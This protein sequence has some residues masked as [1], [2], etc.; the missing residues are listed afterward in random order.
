[1]AIFNKSY[2]KIHKKCYSQ[3]LGNSFPIRP[4][5]ASFCIF[6]SSDAPYRYRIDPR[7]IL[8]ELGGGGSPHFSNMTI[9]GDHHDYLL[10]EHQLIRHT[11]IGYA[12]KE[13]RSDDRVHTRNSVS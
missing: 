2:P 1:M 12:Q 4:D 3:P 6:V 13:K 8:S 9:I 11:Q 7:L 10:D 5:Q